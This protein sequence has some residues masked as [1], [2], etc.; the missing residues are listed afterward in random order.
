MRGFERMILV[1]FA[2]QLNATIDN[3][4]NEDERLLVQRAIL[5]SIR[6]PEPTGRW[7][8]EFAFA[9]RGRLAL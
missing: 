7:I 5:I 6:S 8:A 2:H 4:E 9:D 3:L 1:A